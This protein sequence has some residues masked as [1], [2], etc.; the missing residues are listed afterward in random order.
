MTQEKQAVMTEE[1]TARRE[2][3]M[4]PM[5]THNLVPHKTTRQR[6]QNPAIFLLHPKSKRYDALRAAKFLGLTSREMASLLGVRERILLETP[7]KEAIQPS[8]SPL[9]RL[10]ETLIASFG[11]RPQAIED[12]L[13][14]RDPQLDNK[15][16]R[17]LIKQGMAHILIEMLDGTARG[18]F[19]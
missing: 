17:Q 10:A 18:Q 4:A 2:P 19:A 13:L 14:L 6:T 15:T 9:I 3:N 12:Y 5:S 11:N 8:L 16:P 1:R 7:D